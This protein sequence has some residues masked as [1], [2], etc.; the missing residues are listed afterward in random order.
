MEMVNE[1]K[2]VGYIK[3]VFDRAEYTT[4]FVI[5]IKR[6]DGDYWD[7][8]LCKVNNTK[9]NG[10]L[11]ER[12]M[13]SVAGV[14]RTDSWPVG[15]DGKAV[16]DVKKG[17]KDGNKFKD[18]KGKYFD[19]RIVS[20]NSKTYLMVISASALPQDTEKK[21]DKLVME[22]ITASSGSAYFVD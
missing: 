14:L 8:I 12:N 18:D 19:N 5:S 22:G 9:V 3:R 1:T 17:G 13:V 15:A 10:W 2:L 4:D 16:K 11:K 20:W 6:R 21:F 7:D